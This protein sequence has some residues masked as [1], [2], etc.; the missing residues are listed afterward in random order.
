MAVLLMLLVAFSVPFAGSA[1]ADAGDAGAGL[2]AA[3]EDGAARASGTED[4]PLDAGEEAVADAEASA[5]A[6]T[7]QDA[8]REV[9]DAGPPIAGVPVKLGDRKVFVLRVPRAGNSPEERA[10]TAG[11]ALERALEAS[12]DEDADVHVEEQGGLAVVV[13]GNIPIV[14]LAE[15]DA[16]AAGD[17]SL[18]VHAAAVAASVR[19]A[20]KGERT[21]ARIARTVFSWSL[22]VFTGLVAFLV[23]RRLREI[24]GKIQ[25]F[26]DENPKRIPEL[27]VGTVE[28]MKRG[29]LGVLLRVL[30]SLVERLLQLLAFYLWVVFSLSLFDATREVGKRV[31]G[32]VVE[33]LGLVVGRLASA[34][35]ILAIA[36]IAAGVLGLFLRFLRLFFESVARGETTISW[37]PADLAIPTGR[38]LRVA[39]GVSA[40]LLSAPLVTGTEEGVA[41]AATL[42]LLGAVGLAIVPLLA[43]AIVG[44]AFVF[45]RRL[46]VGDFVMV[47]GRQ[48]RVAELTLIELRMHDGDGAEYRVPYLSLLVRPIRVMGPVPT[49][50]IELAVDPAA[51][52]ARVREV[53]L[54]AGSFAHGPPRVR[55]IGVDADGAHYEITA[56]RAPEE[57]DAATT[58]V[59]ALQ[60]AGIALGRARPR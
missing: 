8:A 25:Q 26:L 54:A 39:L 4:S 1:Y 27:R 17:A 53:L 60:A 6:E 30:L 19:E 47:E 28:I 49:S 35:P 3:G 31:T 12:E 18:Q 36:I 58:L 38:V 32:V 15:E 5:L 7:G 29:A 55:L 52:Q 42:V 23:L 13:A 56:R 33:P 50:V 44:I 14:Q 10:R 43:T 59:E 48:G 22:V 45:W 21:R 34:L 57:P 2:L 37:L 41:R 51:P 40:V 16:R 11:A 9:V 24:K 46:R 20:L